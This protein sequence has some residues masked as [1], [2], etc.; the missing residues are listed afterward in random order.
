MATLFYENASTMAT[1]TPVKV[2]AS[3]VNLY[4]SDNFYTTS[5]ASDRNLP[6]TSSDTTNCTGAVIALH[7]ASNDA[8]QSVTVKLQQ[9]IASVWTDVA[10][11]TKTLTYAEIHGTHV[12]SASAFCCLT[13]FKF[14]TPA[15]INTTASTWRIVAK[16]TNSSAKIMNNSSSASIYAIISD[17]ALAYSSGDIIFIN[18]NTTLTL[19]LTTT[20]TSVFLGTNSSIEW[21][22]PAVAAYTLTI[23]NVYW[24]K[25][26][27]IG[28]GSQAN[29]IATAN[30]GTLVITNNYDGNNAQGTGL[31]WEM[32]G[33]KPTNISTTLSA[34][35]N[36]GQADIVTTDDMSALWANGD[37]L[38]I[39][40]SSDGTH[41]TYTISSMS[42]TTITLTG[43]LAANHYKGFSVFNTNKRT[44]C[45][46]Q[47]NANAPQNAA[48]AVLKMSG[49]SVTKTSPYF[50]I[51]DVV[52]TAT[53][54]TARYVPRLLDTVFFNTGS[55]YSQTSSQTVTL[56]GTYK[57][58]F[59]WSTA[60]SG[61]AIIDS[62]ATHENILTHRTDLYAGFAGTNNTYTNVQL[63]GAASNLSLISMIANTFT[64][65]KFNAAGSINLG[66]INTNFINCSFDR[67]TLGVFVP[68]QTVVNTKL[69]NCDIGSL[70]TVGHA[71]AMAT[72][73]VQLYYENCKI[74]VGTSDVLRTTPVLNGSY[75]SFPTYNQIANTNKYHQ[76]YGVIETTGD[77][78]TDTTVHTSGTGKFATRFEPLSSTNN[79]TWEIDVPTGNIQNKSMTVFVWCKINSATYYAGTHQLPRLTIDYDNGTTAYHQAGESTDWQ[80]LFVTFTPTTT[81]GQITV[82]LSGRTD[83]TTTNAYMYWDDFGVS[84]PPS[85]SL[86]LGGMDNWA[87]GLPVV[88]PISIPISAGTV[89]QAVA[90]L[91]PGEIKYIDAGEKPIY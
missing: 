60:G 28:I 86:D 8:G 87:N 11:A 70:A 6:F 15:A 16:S 36:S 21:E 58:I 25:D 40:G 9:Y 41:T 74:T 4:T 31:E 30:K 48:M 80:L 85:V 71:F 20:L 37:V 57:N 1:T 83:A 39:G 12:Y 82:T 65:C 88:P 73:F 10:G 23:T 52:N 54:D 17:T 45:G 78:L 81:Y 42:G 91:V 14:G 43:N 76:L 46:V 22:N 33:E 89:A 72:F 66:S 26:S 5:L 18:Q 51:K 56:G 68:T 55:T 24:S 19:D 63:T 35:A 62:N 38:S 77:G 69:T 27:R 47:L 59:T 84:Y 2:V 90:L 64:N 44:S 3:V 75:I 61:F 7:M 67:M 49:V 50:L 29:P 53:L 32:W 34:T 13:Y 79:L